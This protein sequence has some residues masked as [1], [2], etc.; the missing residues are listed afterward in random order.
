MV[1]DIGK[2]F[3]KI[4]KEKLDY[5]EARLN[6][7]TSQDDVVSF[8]DMGNTIN[9]IATLTAIIALHEKMLKDA[10]DYVVISRDEYKKL[11]KTESWLMGG[12]K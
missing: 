8:S 4:L 2:Q 12:I 10:G 1:K 9:S 11:Q 7:L 3:S 5:E 6:K